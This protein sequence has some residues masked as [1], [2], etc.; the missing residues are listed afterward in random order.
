MEIIN[1]TPLVDGYTLGVEP[2]GR[3]HLVFVLKGTFHL[4]TPDDDSTL[5]HEE[6]LPLT[7]ADTF[8][9]E[10]GFS[11]P[12][13]EVDFAPKKIRCD[14]LLSGSAWAPGRRPAPRVVVGLRVGA[15]HKAFAVI[16]DRQWSSGP[17]GTRATS[18]V[19]FVSKAISYDVAFGGVDAWS[20]EP[21]KW[22][23]F[24]RNPVGRGWHHHLKSRYVDGTP[25]PNT[26]EL[27]RTVVTPDGDYEPM[28]FGP[29]GRGWSARLPFAGTYDQDWIDNTF[30]F[31][32]ADFRQEYYQAA[33]PDQQID[34]PQG[35]EEVSLI[36]LTPAGRVDFRLPAIDV[37]VHFFLRS[38]GHEKRSAV[39]DTLTFRPDE[40][41]FTMTWRASVSLKKASL[42]SQT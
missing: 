19:P 24:G 26:E 3:E 31:L 16:G 35:G 39:L 38:G 2:S 4:P 8:T 5:F 29:L 10:P 33:P 27:A 37:P 40:G 34:Y 41:L 32:P 18:P 12:V 13:E 11:A 36:N 22:K 28:S 14:V 6:Q 1:N 9:G 25:M 42:R 21:D 20:E 15:W 30:P 23:A 17:M 7:V